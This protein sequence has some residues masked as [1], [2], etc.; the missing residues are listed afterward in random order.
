MRD[1]LFGLRHDSVVGGDNQNG[2]VGDVGTTRS[3]FCEGLVTRGV[4]KGNGSPILLDLVSPNVLRDPSGF[5]RYDLGTDQ[6]IQQ[7]CLAV[8]DVPQERHDRCTCDQVLWI[9]NKIV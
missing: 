9:I 3:H 6:V 2:D 4:D 8:V 5:T 7:R 1:G